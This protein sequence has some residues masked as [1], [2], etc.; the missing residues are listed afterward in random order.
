M[1]LGGQKV[2]EEQKTLAQSV[3]R[4]GREG[5]RCNR[6]DGERLAAGCAGKVGVPELRQFDQG[7]EP[8]IALAIN[9]RCDFGMTQGRGLGPTVRVA[10]RNKNEAR[11]RPIG[12]RGHNVNIKVIQI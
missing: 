5:P 1:E 9:P 12:Y 4:D 10:V 8:T 3:E 2:P 6:L 7:F 11:I